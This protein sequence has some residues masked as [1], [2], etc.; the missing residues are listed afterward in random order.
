MT[1]QRPPELGPQYEAMMAQIDLKL[2]NEGVDIPWRPMFAM[3]EVSMTYN[4]SMP[5]G[6]DA[7]RMPPE[8]HENAALS[9]AIHKW[10]EDNYGDLLKEDLCPGRMVLLLDGDLYVLRVPRIFG[11]VKFVLTRQWLPNP[12]IG[13]GPATWVVSRGVV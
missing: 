8:L 3:R 2:I 5:F 4:L 13:R 11:S 10:Y 7:V 1:F 6:G 12:G 9:E